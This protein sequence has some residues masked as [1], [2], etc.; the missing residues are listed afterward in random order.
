ML[1]KRTICRHPCFFQSLDYTVICFVT[2]SARFGICTVMVLNRTHVEANIHT[3][4]QG[5]QVH[6][7][8]S[9]CPVWA[10]DGADAKFNNKRDKTVYSVL[11]QMTF[12]TKVMMTSC[13]QDLPN[14]K[15]QTY[16]KRLRVAVPS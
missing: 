6:F 9:K 7:S 16:S 12:K 10:H 5:S 15:P 11:G 2:I 3:H 13:L 8:F 1:V 14:L 4:I